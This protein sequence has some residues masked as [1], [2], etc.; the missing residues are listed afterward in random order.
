[1]AVTTVCFILFLFFFSD[2]KHINYFK[3]I[4]FVIQFQYECRRITTHLLR[5]G[6]KWHCSYSEDELSHL[7]KHTVIFILI[8]FP[9]NLW[10][11][12]SLCSM[13]TDR[14]YIHWK[15]FLNQT[16][17]RVD[18]SSEPMREKGNRGLASR[19]L[20]K[21]FMPPPECSHCGSVPSIPALCCLL[22]EKCRELLIRIVWSYNV[23]F[24]LN[25]MRI[26]LGV[27]QISL[28]LGLFYH[29]MSFALS[30]A[31]CSKRRCLTHLSVSWVSE[32]LSMSQ[33]LDKE[34]EGHFGE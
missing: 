34:L 1:M 30:L 32:A 22:Q 6:Q 3:S 23:G 16:M 29:N 31:Y 33:A 15:C 14:E 10:L 12:L 27:L 25:L 26:S 21:H 28:W 4:C 13:S 9:R 7:L 20:C 5:R 17:P 19:G 24:L 18:L 2:S 11:P 8:S